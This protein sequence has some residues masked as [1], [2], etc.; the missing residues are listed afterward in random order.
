MSDESVCRPT[1]PK[2]AE[3]TAR[4]RSDPDE[5]RVLAGLRAND[6]GSYEQLVRAYAGRMLSVAFRFVRN[7]E[8]A[9]DCVQDAFLQAFRAID[10]FAGRASLGTW[11]HRIVVNVAL[12][13]IRARERR[14]EE[15]LDEFLPKF[16]ASGHRIEQEVGLSDSIESL[17]ERNETREFVRRCIDRLPKHYRTIL[18]V[19]DIDGYDTAETAAVLGLKAGTVKTRLHRAR[20][21]LKTMIE[22]RQRG[23]EWSPPTS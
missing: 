3:D 9:S 8:D 14:Q 22:S 7:R 10:R 12:T 11:L 20:A 5:A 16:D 4:T 2:P 13:R 17:L 15:S 19:R 18:L 1:E 6:P 23:D 21:A